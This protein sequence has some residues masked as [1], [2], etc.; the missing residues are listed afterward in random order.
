MGG[1]EK[2]GTGELVDAGVRDTSS[3][4]YNKESVQKSLLCLVNSKEKAKVSGMTD[5]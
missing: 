2:R 5:R 3:I 1:G 4:W